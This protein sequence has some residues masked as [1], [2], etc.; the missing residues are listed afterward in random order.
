MAPAASDTI[1]Q[2]LFD[3]GRV[4]EDYDAVFTGDLGKVGQKILLDYSF[5]KGV[6]ILGVSIRTAVF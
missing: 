3:F 1:W 5:L 4:P 2:N 6:L